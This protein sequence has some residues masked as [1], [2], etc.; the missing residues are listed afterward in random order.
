MCTSLTC[1]QRKKPLV[2]ATQNGQLE[3]SLHS[4]PPYGMVNLDIFSCEPF[5]A[6]AVAR[7]AC[8]KFQTQDIEIHVVERATRSPR[9]AQL[10]P[11]HQGRTMLNQQDV[12]LDPHA[13]TPV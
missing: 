13:E 4:W 3:I 8:D 5:D 2:S 12:H 1:L 10:E 7:F 9:L 6:E 11:A